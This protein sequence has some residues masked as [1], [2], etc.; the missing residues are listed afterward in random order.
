MKVEVINQA[1][2]HINYMD[3]LKQ[4]FKVGFSIN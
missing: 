2:A 3:L 4:E 1:K